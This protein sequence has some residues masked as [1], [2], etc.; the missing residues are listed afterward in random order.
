MLKRL[1]A[2][3]HCDARRTLDDGLA[4]ILNLPDLAT[5]RTLL[6]SE[7]VVCNRRLWGDGLAR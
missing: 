2:M 3:A 5:L 1:P 4:R 7:P 6:A